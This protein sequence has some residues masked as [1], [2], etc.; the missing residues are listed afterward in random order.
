MNARLTGGPNEPLHREMRLTIGVCIAAFICFSH[1]AL[2][3]DS[4]LT[5]IELYDGASGPAYVQ[6]SDVLINGKAELRSCAGAAADTKIDKSAY[7]KFPKLMLAPGTTLERDQDGVLRLSAVGGRPD[8]VVPD[9]VKF[10]HSSSLTASELADRADLNARGA[11]DGI[12]A[13]ALKRGVTLV[14]V[15]AFDTEIAE[16]LLAQRIGEIQGWKSYLSKY[17]AALHSD[18]AKQALASLFVDCAKRSLD[19]YK[20]SADSDSPSYAELKNARTQDVAAKALVPGLDS[21]QRSLAEV[22]ETLVN[23]AAKGQS[24]LQ[25][26]N[27]S[28]TSSQPG[29]RHLQKAEKL[30]ESVNSIDPDLPAGRKLQIDAVQARN[31]YEA[32]LRA[33][34]EASKAKQ[35]SQSMK[36]LGSI[37]PFASEDGRVQELIDAA[38]ARLYEQGKQF[39]DAKDW[40]NAIDAYHGALTA[41]DTAE[42]R[43]KLSAAKAELLAAQNKAAADTALQKSKEQESQKDLI[44]AYE[45]LAS[46]PD[47]QQ[48]L[49]SSEIERLE[50]LYITAASDNAKQI[51]KLFPTIGGIGDERAVETAYR[52]LKN[53]QE[54]STD[55]ATKQ[56]FQE[57]LQNLA[58]ELS[59]WFLE[60]AKHCLQKPLGSGTEL[61]WSYLKEAEPYKAA[62]LELVQDQVKVTAIPHGMHSKL[63]IRVQFRDQTSQRQS[64]GFANQM[65]NA[66]ATGLDNSGIPV[67]IV[68]SGDT[69]AA[70]SQ[71]DF[72]IAGDVLE[73]NI[74]APPTE[75]SI[76]SKYI[77]GV[78][79]IA[80]EKW[81]KL[82]RLYDSAISELHTAQA[83]LG[84]VTAKGN[85]KQIAEANKAVA[86]AQKKVD[87]LRLQLD[88]TPKSL[89]ED[90]FRSYRYRKT[91][92]NV[93]NRIVIQFRIDDQIGGERGPTVQVAKEDR[94]QFVVQSD[95][96]P[97][98]V[99]NI[100]AQGTIPDKTEMQTELENNTREELIRKVQDAVIE[101]PR[102]IYQDARKREDDSYADDAGEAYLRY[103]NVAPP[104]QAQEREHAEKYLNEQFNFLTFPPAI[105]FARPPQP[106]IEQGHMNS[107]K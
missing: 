47:D 63:S 21:A 100:R 76:E 10:E 80:N 51:A 36:Q 93:I 59:T 102:K 90:I 52:Y 67:K 18:S 29:L 27:L 23:L 40:R 48:K 9:N 56:A 4:S 31:S 81:E 6:I 33:A 53:A 66:I 98:D 35:W 55:D 105:P 69:T 14:F 11:V 79:D 68:R 86:D 91:T 13:Q 94:Q 41:K 43:E 19:S 92:Y 37:R 42:V 44:G 74:S 104:E 20:K 64:E 25:A 12:P 62:N 30:S 82:N 83:T 16:Y 71:P 1:S 61:G 75:E 26:Y 39:D 22:Q 38:Y 28:L 101:L 89:S 107:G 34:T 87:D 46:L 88:S 85:K 15:A 84:G 99:N 54:L 106:A 65:E 97:S 70:D 17:P 96:E 49:V 57:R 73:H 58:D 2:A 95:V 103:L 24:E 50:P 78:H 72:V 32:V 77:A 45:A 8:C 3:R 5:A 7:S 60:R